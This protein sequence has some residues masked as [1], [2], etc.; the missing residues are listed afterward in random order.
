MS[1]ESDISLLR[2]IPLFAELPTEQ[3]RQLA[4][5][6]VRLEL[7]EGHVLFR[8]ATKAA[9][10]FV[11]SS[12]E[13]ELTAGTGDKRRVVATC[14]V[15]SLIGEIALFVE[16]K[17]PATATAVAAS[18]VLEVERKVILRM[19]S[20]YPQIAVKMRAALSERLSAT[21][22]ELTRVRQAL[23]TA[24]RRGGPRL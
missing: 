10:G 23:A 21:M 7:P 8:E 15:G 22:G 1:L 6:A 11:V 16:T 19:L 2:S 3:L 9:S 17:R 4:F 5:S 13:I 24:G 20:E 14:E 18:Q 12:G